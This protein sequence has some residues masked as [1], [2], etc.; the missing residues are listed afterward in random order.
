MHESTVSLIYAPWNLDGFGQSLDES[1]GVLVDIFD[2]LRR[3]RHCFLLK[4]SNYKLGCRIE[5]MNVGLKVRCVYASSPNRNRRLFGK[6]R[7][8]R[9][10]EITGKDEFTATTTTK[11]ST[12]EKA[13]ITRTMH[14]ALCFR[15]ASWVLRKSAHLQPAD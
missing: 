4:A 10:Y 13:V 7:T 12:P 14:Y 2:K 5:E 3:C 6:L 1:I 15:K 8:N 9:D 11:H